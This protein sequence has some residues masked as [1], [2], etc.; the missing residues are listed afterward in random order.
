MYLSTGAYTFGAHLVGW[1]QPGAFDTTV[2]NLDAVIQV[3]KLAERGGFDSLFLAD[4]N[5]VEQLENPELLAAGSPMDRAAVFEPSTLMAALSQHTDRIGLFV[6]ATTTYDEP[7]L[8][9]RRLGSLD[10]LSKGRAV[11]NVVT[12]SN[13]G[14]SRNF[15]F[16]AHM[17]KSER[18]VRASEFVDVCKELWDSWAD[19]AFP[20]DK[21]SGHYLRPDR[22]HRTEHVG[23]HFS[24]GGPLNVARS[25]QG[26][27]L[28]AVAGQSEGGRD[29]A[30]RHAD[31]VIAAATN[32]DDA[33]ELRADIRKRAAA[34][35]RDP[36]TIRLISST[37]VYLRD[38]AAAARAYQS[39][40]ASSIPEAVGVSYL[41]K[42]VGEDMSRY[43]LDAP[44]PELSADVVGIAGIRATI[45]AMAQRQG[46][47]I[48]ETYRF[49][50]RSTPAFVGT[51]SMIADELEDWYRSGACDGFNVAVPTLP[52]G[53]E[54][55]VDELMP[56]LRTRGLRPNEH[57]TGTLR[58]RLRLG[59]PAN[60]YFSDARVEA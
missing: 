54:R 30:A 31:L 51:A 41:S 50:S 28:I 36:D 37:T 18:Y 26:Y 48:R 25:P 6:T 22:V 13:P 55:V 3:A 20:Q 33:A 52:A 46:L 23:T 35:G 39:A 21:E 49:L 29:L 27:P 15:G 14:D 44:F 34:I 7:Y 32:K 57:A 24:I 53:L 10:H 38:T 5:G 43:D 11:W 1:R 58:E 8:L 19:D 16:A 2:M 47:T 12:G 42:L 40:L 4:G 56:V 45:N 59:R 9:A 17:D 60:P